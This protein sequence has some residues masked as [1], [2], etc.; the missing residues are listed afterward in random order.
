MRR[1]TGFGS[2]LPSAARGDDY[3]SGKYGTYFWVDP[4]ED[5]TCVM[6]MAA[7]GPVRVRYREIIRALVYQAIAD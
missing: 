5:L 2:A 1:A 7:P 6:M 3:W 4:F